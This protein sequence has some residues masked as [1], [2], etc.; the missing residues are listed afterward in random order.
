MSSVYYDN[1][2]MDSYM[3][4]LRRDDKATAIRIR[5]YGERSTSGSQEVYLERKVHREAWT[6]ERSCKVNK[7]LFLLLSL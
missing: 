2:A 3:S 1:E 5:F 4:R 7:F 6:G